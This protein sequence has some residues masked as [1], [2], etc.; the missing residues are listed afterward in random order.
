MRTW[1]SKH[2]DGEMNSKA[3][4]S[5]NSLAF[6][7][8][9]YHRGGVTRWMVDMAVGW[10]KQEHSCW[11]I[12]PRPRSPFTSGARRMTLIDLLEIY[13]ADHRPTIVELPVGSE[14]EFGTLAYRAAVYSHAIVSS[15]PPNVPVVVSDDPAAWMAAAHV[16]SR[17]PM[18]GVLHSDDTS[19]YE[20]ARRHRKSISTLV[21]V[22]EKVTTRAQ[23]VEEFSSS[24]VVTIP[25]GIPLKPATQEEN[26]NPNQR[27]KL[28]WVGRVEEQQK[29]I[30]DLPRI[31][32][33]L[34]SSGLEFDLVIV[35]DGPGREWLERALVED[36]LIRYVRLLGWQPTHEVMKLLAQ[37]DILLLPSNYEGMPISVMEAL[38]AG[39][40]IV[41]SRVSGIEDYEQ[42]PLA[43]D[44]LWVYSVGDISE[45]ARLVKLAATIPRARR[46]LQAQALAA[47]EFSIEKCVERYEDLIGRLRSDKT[48]YRTA[49]LPNYWFSALIS[50]PIAVARVVRLHIA[51]N[52]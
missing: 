27:L 50:R 46:S 1:F 37:S 25:C 29:R 52:Y 42:H 16:S 10:R 3:Q 47:A 19:Y 51:G 41:A 48:A 31:A 33:Q 22:S 36:G 6:V 14:F 13:P 2:S 4:M 11:F 28:I 20:L 39:C 7:C 9:P 17:N 43:K 49:R 30:S 38:S 8:H 32:K 44:C 18:I 45:A 40:G 26:A 15:V 21:S 34:K 24:T 5:V 12:T 35:G 23:T